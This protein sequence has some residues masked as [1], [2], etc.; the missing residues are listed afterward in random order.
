MAR[1]QQSSVVKPLLSGQLTRREVLTGAAGAVGVVAASPIAAQ[2]ALETTRRPGRG[3]NERD[4]RSPFVDPR[5]DPSL[6]SSR[7]PLQD[8]SGTLTPADLHFERHHAG[9]PEIDPD[10]YEL[11]IHGMVE[12]PTVFSLADLRRF[13]ATSRIC[14]LE[15]S[16]N[17]RRGA[18][19]TL[20][21][22]VCGLTSQTEWTGVKLSTLL[23]EVGA[24]RDA[25]WFLAEGQ[26]AAVM[27]R[28]IP[29]FKAFDDAMIVYAQNG[30][31]LMP[32]NGF[33]ARL[34]LPGWEGNAS[35]KWLRR[36]ELA[37]Q[38]FMTREETSKYTDPLGDGSTVRQFSFVMDARS[39]ITD[40]AYPRVIE[41]GWH[42]IRGLAWSGR[43]RITQVEVSTDGGVTWQ[44]AELQAP[45]L[46]KA[47][48]R[49]RTPWNWTGAATEILSR[50]TDETG[51]VQ[52][53]WEVLRAARG[54]R[55]RYHQNPITSWTI[56]ENG[57]VLFGADRLRS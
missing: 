48:V 49:F 26:D 22:M 23:N 30:D 14:F 52:P 32:G 40:P 45:V 15:C 8:L 47:H 37:S 7:T 41:P 29:M 55:T 5:R 19:E 25:T 21:Q 6:T 50:A 20:P 54:P 17:L 56:G 2:E 43:G 13:P 44:A 3:P 28:S 33:P 4:Q 39:I 12:R 11:L 1:N 27:T 18:P 34:L 57:Q 10:R 46:P 16:G 35:V 9:V 42:E 31:A 53:T 36:I 38:P 51:Y 24:N